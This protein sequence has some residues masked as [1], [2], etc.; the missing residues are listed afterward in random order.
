MA[1]AATPHFS[2]AMHKEREFDRTESGDL[3]MNMVSPL[4]FLFL[5]GRTAGGRETCIKKLLIEDWRLSENDNQS[6]LR[7]RNCDG[8]IAKCGCRPPR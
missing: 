8:R 7:Y 4:A 6:W 3:V 2:A 1:A 5:K